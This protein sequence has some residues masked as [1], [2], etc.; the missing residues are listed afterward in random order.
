M[1]QDIHLGRYCSCLWD[2]CY[3]GSLAAEARPYISPEA[4]IGWVAQHFT[5]CSPELAPPQQESLDRGKSLDPSEGAGTLD[6]TR[7]TM[8]ASPHTPTVWGHT[9]PDIRATSCLQ[10][11]LKGGSTQLGAYQPISSQGRTTS[12][13]PTLLVQG[14]GVVLWRVRRPTTCDRAHSLG[15]F[16]AVAAALCV[17]L[18]DSNDPAA[19]SPTATLLRLLLPL[20]AEYRPD[21]KGVCPWGTWVVQKALPSNHR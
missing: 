18:C 8:P 1:G 7:S 4:I 17:S 6:R 16:T 3:R 2:F 9:W 13:R 14:S 5:D 20:A 12:D 19:G 10:R 21:S 15:S 11:S